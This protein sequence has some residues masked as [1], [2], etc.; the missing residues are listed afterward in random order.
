MNEM[1]CKTKK[2]NRYGSNNSKYIIEINSII[3]AFYYKILV[4]CFNLVYY[5]IKF[6]TFLNL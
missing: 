6:I 2:L 3:K 1:K 4:K 5:T